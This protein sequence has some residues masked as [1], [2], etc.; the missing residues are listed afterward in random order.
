MRKW[1]F[2]MAT[3]TREERRWKVGMS[4]VR[5]DGW[6]AGKYRYGGLGRVSAN[7]RRRELRR[8]IEI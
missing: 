5:G 8:G 3:I 1:K 4:A 6:G 7:T 2:E